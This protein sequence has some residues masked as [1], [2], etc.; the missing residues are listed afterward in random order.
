MV[1][2]TSEHTCTDWDVGSLRFG[3]LAGID[4]LAGGCCLAVA[5]MFPAA[6]WLV[7]C[8]LL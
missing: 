2:E 7:S 8:S 5:W 1:G 4:F 6:S 3:V